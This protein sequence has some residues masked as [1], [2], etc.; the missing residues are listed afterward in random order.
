MAD[1]FSDMGAPLRWCLFVDGA[2]VYRGAKVHLEAVLVNRDVLK[3]GDYPVRFQ[4]VGPR[5]TRVMDTTITV[6]VSG[7]NE[8]P[9]AQ[10]VFSKDVV[11]DGPPGRYRFLATFQR[12]AAAAGYHA[13]FYVED[14]A[15]KPMVPVEVVLWSKDEELSAWFRSQGI[16]VRESLTPAQ[17]ARE[18]ILATGTPP[19]DDRAAIFS[20]LARRVGRGSAVVFLTPDTLLDAPFA[21]HAPQ[22]L[23]WLPTDSDARP[24]IAHTPEWY[25][26]ADPWAKEHPVF[27]DLPCGGILDY[28]FYR[29]IISAT[30]FRNLQA[31]VEA[32][33]GAIQTSGGPD[34]YCSDLLVAEYP[35]GAGRIVVNSLRLRENVGR[36]PAA[37]KLLLNLINYA[38]RDSHKPIADLRPDFND[39]LRMNWV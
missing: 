38:A 29:E 34:D 11:V 4:L 19:S 24:M 8:A 39:R 12:G 17:S 7:Q 36:V 23:R 2:N 26:H 18:L 27:L 13:E 20:E 6:K 21:S 5:V 9:F 28:T 30:V 35:L 32:I 10:P 33:C 16:A 22:P 37:D 25:F 15:T 1:A 14:P 3:A 31:P